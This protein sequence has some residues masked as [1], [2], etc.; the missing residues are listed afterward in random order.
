[1][2]IFATS[3]AVVVVTLAADP[4]PMGYEDAPRVGEPV[5]VADLI[6]FDDLTDRV[7]AQVLDLE[8]QFRPQFRTLWAAEV[9]FVCRVSDLGPSDQAQ[10]R[11][12]QEEALQGAVRQW[13]LV[14]VQTGGHGRVARHSYQPHR[15]VQ[16]KVKELVHERLEAAALAHY[17]AEVAKRS[18][19]LK[20]V[21]IQSI[22]A[23][24]DRRLLLS[25][26]QRSDLASRLAEDWQ[27]QWGK[28]LR[29]RVGRDQQ[30]PGLPDHYLIPIL[31]EAQRRV[32]NHSRKKS[33]SVPFAIEML[34]RAA[35]P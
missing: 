30:L 3:I 32:W 24:L 7:R 22:V 28:V 27:E 2:Q 26:Q 10:I 6:A 14:Q 5:N 8:E 9:A 31:T 20:T 34:P 19:H 13:A 11:R 15:F 17:D 1:M 23:H 35:Q 4:L 18:A 12:G 16:A 29:L 33:F 21:S 25:P